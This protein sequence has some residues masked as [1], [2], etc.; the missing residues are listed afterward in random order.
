MTS[1][2]AVAVH[3]L[4]FLNHK[5]VVESS[6][7]IA[8]NVCTHP[9]RLRRVLA[10]LKKAG[11]LETREGASGG[12]RFSEDAS[13]VT[14]DMVAAALAEKPV[15]VKYRT[16]ALDKECQ[17]SSGMAGIMD[18]IYDEMNA[19]CYGQLAAITIANKKKKIFG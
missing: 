3:A 13:T 6:E 9:V 4:V 19:A 7:Q 16:G 1:D 18:D 10:K 14:L 2:F 8:E 15:D 12:C 17:I 11:L 5:Q